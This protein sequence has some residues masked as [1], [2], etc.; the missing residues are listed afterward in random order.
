MDNIEG[1]PPAAVARLKADIL[2]DSRVKMPDFLTRCS[3]A[4]KLIDAEP[5]REL[6]SKPAM[7]ESVL[8]LMRQMAE[9]YDAAVRVFFSSETLADMGP[10]GTSAILD[11]T[12]KIF[13]ARNP[14]LSG[15]FRKEFAATLSELLDKDFNR[16]HAKLGDPKLTNAEMKVAQVEFTKLSITS[17]FLHDMT[18]QG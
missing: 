6:L 15:V 10:D 4:A 5:M 2:K 18:F 13:F 11:H 14:G 8:E 7:P 17:A 16:V 12:F 1:L 3:D 9:H